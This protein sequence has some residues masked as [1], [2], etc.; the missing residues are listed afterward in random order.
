[1]THLS[2]FHLTT[3]T[4]FNNVVYP[5]NHY[6]YYSCGVLKTYVYLIVGFWLPTC[7]MLLVEEEVRQVFMMKTRAR[8]R[9]PLSP[10]WVVTITHMAAVFVIGCYVIWQLLNALLLMLNYF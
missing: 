1:M 5:D 3:N 4:F 10:N 7:V 6:Y 9:M 2:T 8:V